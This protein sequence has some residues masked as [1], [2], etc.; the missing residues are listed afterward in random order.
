MDCPPTF[1]AATFA[2]SAESTSAVLP[3]HDKGSDN[4]KADERGQRSTINRKE[5]AERQRLRSL[6]AR[7][8]VGS[9]NVKADEGEQR[10]K[11]NEK[12]EEERRSLRSLAALAAVAKA[13]ANLNS[14]RGVHA[15]RRAKRLSLE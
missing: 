2:A 15:G 6:A 1:N 12:E 8:A 5:E 13:K 11:I 14:L 10:S 4:V 3:V 7:A 9:N